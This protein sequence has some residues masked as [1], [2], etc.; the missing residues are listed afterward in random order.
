MYTSLGGIMAYQNRLGWWLSERHNVLARVACFT[1]NKLYERKHRKWIST[2]LTYMGTATVVGKSNV[3][4]KGT[5]TQR[6]HVVKK[7]ARRLYAGIR[8]QPLTLLRYFLTDYGCCAVFNTGGNKLHYTVRNGRIQCDHVELCS[9]LCCMHQPLISLKPVS[10]G[11]CLLSVILIRQH[12][13]QTTSGCVRKG[14]LLK[15]WNVLVA[16]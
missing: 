10:E 15:Q 6:T 7:C 14:W 9:A 5:H 3:F 8:T 11:P 1:R 13:Y 4:N 12:R 16:L 2:V